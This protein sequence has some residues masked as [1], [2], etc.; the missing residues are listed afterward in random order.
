MTST[1]YGLPYA[2]AGFD[3]AEL[4]DRLIT[5]KHPEAEL[6]FKQ[7]LVLSKTKEDY[8]SCRIEGIPAQCGIV[9]YCKWDWLKFDML[10]QHLENCHAIARRLRYTKA[11]ITH[12]D[13]VFI[14]KLVDEHGWK[15]IEEF[16]NQR[17]GNIVYVAIFDL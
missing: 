15:V 16:K 12:N 5:Y 6:V 1:L 7:N 4:Q 10:K 17:S 3:S 14:N 11:M 9:L 2:S 13:E 8:V